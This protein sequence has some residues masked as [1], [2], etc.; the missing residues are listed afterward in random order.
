MQP[1][2]TKVSDNSLH[3]LPIYLPF[4]PHCLT[5]LPAAKS[6]RSQTKVTLSQYYTD[7]WQWQQLLYF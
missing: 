1:G 7:A 2:M 6:A 5:F 3:Y 4:F